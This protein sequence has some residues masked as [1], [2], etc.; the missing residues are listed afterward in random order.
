M[1]RSALIAFA[2]AS[3]MSTSAL[4]ADPVVKT[5]YGPVAGQR[6]E[7]VDAFKGVPFAAPPV[8][9]LRWRAP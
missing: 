9:D 4:A 2:A 1:H 5:T 6:T 7:G 3:F 8:G